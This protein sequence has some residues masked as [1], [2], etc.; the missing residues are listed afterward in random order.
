V[1]AE[2][3]EDADVRGHDGGAGGGGVNGL[4]D[5]DGVIRNLGAAISVVG[6]AG[7]VEHGDRGVEAADLEVGDGPPAVVV[8]A[9]GDEPEEALDVGGGP[10]AGPD[11]GSPAGGRRPE[12]NVVQA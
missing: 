8:A 3:V 2:A 12:G 7:A 10:V 9:P 11:D 1:L 6:A 5:L 4:G